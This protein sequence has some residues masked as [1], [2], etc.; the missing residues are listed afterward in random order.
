M[1][2]NILIYLLCVSLAFITC[3]KSDDEVTKEY[4][5]AYLKAMMPYTNN[6]AVSFS[7][8]SGMTVNAIVTIS[9]AFSNFGICSGCG[10]LT[11]PEKLTYTFNAG[12]NK[13][14]EFSLTPQPN[15]GLSIYSPMNSYQL[16]FGFTFLVESTSQ[17]SCGALNQVCLPSITLNGRT[18]TNVLELA[19]PGSTTISK[20]YYTVSQGLV[21][22]AYTS[23]VAFTLN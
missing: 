16:G 22:F 12:A 23:G 5:P 18:F 10:N 21:A 8:G 4:V 13:F 2:I 3:K 1:K 7:N 9:S 17:P 19:P 11:N 15:I 20:A 14:F 6:Q